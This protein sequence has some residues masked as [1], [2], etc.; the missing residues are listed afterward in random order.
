MTTYRQHL[1]ALLEEHEAAQDASLETARHFPEVRDDAEARAYRISI[2]AT[3]L[4]TELSRLPTGGI[5]E[6][7]AHDHCLNGDCRVY[8]S[9]DLGNGNTVRY[10]CFGEVAPRE[11]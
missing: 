9:T 2:V 1:T 5:V 11:W 6:P 8:G 4:R 3:L 7:A 10:D